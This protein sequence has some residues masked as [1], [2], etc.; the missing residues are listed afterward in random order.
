[1]VPH[2]FVAYDVDQIQGTY[3]EAGS[4]V[5]VP[6]W[7]NVLLPIGSLV[8]DGTTAWSLGQER[9]AGAT[10]EDGYYA[11]RGLTHIDLSA[12]T[13]TAPFPFWVFSSAVRFEFHLQLNKDAATRRVSAM[14]SSDHST[15]FGITFSLLGPRCRPERGICRDSSL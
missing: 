9:D 2:A 1:V 15:W 4:S 11:E 13:T 7:A 3:L 8:L 12:A 14:E 6:V 5:R 10:D